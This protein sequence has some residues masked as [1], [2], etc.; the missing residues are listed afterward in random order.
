MELTDT[1][2]RIVEGNQTGLSFD[3]GRF[4]VR[5]LK[6]ALLCSK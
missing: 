1:V 5:A 2:R 4:A 6:V 3:N